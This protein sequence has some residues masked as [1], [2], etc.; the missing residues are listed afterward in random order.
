MA[1]ASLRPL[2]HRLPSVRRRGPAA[3]RLAV[4]Q[5]E[6]RTV[7]S[8]LAAIP[9]FSSALPSSASAGGVSQPF[10]SYDGRYIVYTAT[11]PNLVPGQVNTAPAANIYLYD[12]FNST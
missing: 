3:V 9:V 5:L 11:A 4:E 2:R 1:N 6:D 7:L 10:L 8:T 12:A